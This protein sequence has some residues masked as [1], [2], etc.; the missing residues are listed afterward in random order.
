[1]SKSWPCGHSFI[2]QV[3]N[4]ASV[5]QWVSEADP[6]LPC[7]FIDCQESKAFDFAQ[8]KGVCLQDL[9][10]IVSKLLLNFADLL[11]GDAKR[12]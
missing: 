9:E 5:A 7:N 1:M 8:L 10:A 12:T 6:R 2:Q 4:G 11:E 3:L